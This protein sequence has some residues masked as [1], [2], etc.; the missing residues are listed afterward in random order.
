MRSIIWD[1][2]EHRP[3]CPVPFGEHEHVTFAQGVDR[4]LQ[5]GPVLCVLAAGLLPVDLVAPLRAESTELTV[6]VLM[7]R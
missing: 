5:L 2:V 1:T 3:R 4:L 7:R 6:Q